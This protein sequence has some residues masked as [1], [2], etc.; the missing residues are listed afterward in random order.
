MIKN[1]EADL[2]AVST[3]DIVYDSIDVERLFHDEKASSY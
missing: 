2:T 3:D 1:I